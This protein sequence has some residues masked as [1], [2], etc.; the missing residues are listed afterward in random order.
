MQSVSQ[1]VKILPEGLWA[2]VSFKERALEEATQK[3]AG[4]A[5]RSRI[6]LEDGQV[7]LYSRVG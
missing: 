7:F 1:A 4:L 6:S 5:G 2:A 3:R